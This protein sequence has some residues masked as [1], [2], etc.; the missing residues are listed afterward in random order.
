MPRE[1]TILMAAD[2]TRRNLLNLAGWAAFFASLTSMLAGTIRFF[3]PRVLYEPPTVFRAGRLEDHPAGDPDEH[4]VTLVS[5]RWKREHRVWIVREKDRLYCILARCTHLGC[6]PNWS[7][8]DRAFLCPCHG[9][10]FH[11]NGANFAGP[12]PRPLDRLKIWLGEDG[13]ITIDKAEIF[14]AKDFNH[15]NAFLKV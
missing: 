15:P 5:E 1:E 2:L 12:P 13:H 8:A 3:Y 4:G 14:V 6:T 11:S 10:Q 9:G 7:E